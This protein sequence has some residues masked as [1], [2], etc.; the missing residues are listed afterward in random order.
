MPKYHGN[1]NIVLA[2]VPS[3]KCCMSAA[4]PLIATHLHMNQIAFTNFPYLCLKDYVEVV[5]V[6]WL[7]STVN[8]WEEECSPVLR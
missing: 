8:N 6:H 1:I 3:I 2:K 4:L 7:V 5:F